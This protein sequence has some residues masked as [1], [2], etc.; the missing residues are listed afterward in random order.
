MVYLVQFSLVISLYRV[1]Y[2]PLM[3][4]E[5]NYSGK[6]SMKRVIEWTELD[7]TRARKLT[8][9]STI[10]TYLLIIVIALLGSPRNTY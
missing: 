10:F 8:P 6:L 2:Y 3:E 7:I 9:F 5:A 1:I 4:L